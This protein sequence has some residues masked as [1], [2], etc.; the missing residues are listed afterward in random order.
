MNHINWMSVYEYSDSRVYQTHEYRMEFLLG[1]GLKWVWKF[2]CHAYYNNTTGAFVD[3]LMMWSRLLTALFRSLLLVLRS[4]TN[5]QRKKVKSLVQMTFIRFLSTAYFHFVEVYWK[6]LFEKEWAHWTQ[7]NHKW[8][9]IS[10][11]SGYVIS[12]PM[13]IEN[14]RFHCSL[15]YRVKCP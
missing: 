9:L 13:A 6:T 7:Y 4:H 10:M 11:S 2:C 5:Q 14:K 1:K 15:L 12:V 8:V 3:I